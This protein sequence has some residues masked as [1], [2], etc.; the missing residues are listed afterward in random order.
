AADTATA[1]I[2]ATT[3]WTAF[4]FQ[5]HTYALFNGDGNATF[6]TGVDSLVELV[7]VHVAD[8]TGANFA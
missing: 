2:T 1:N 6:D 3:E 4:T 8:L 5:G 7:G